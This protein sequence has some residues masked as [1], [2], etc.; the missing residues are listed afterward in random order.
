MCK[1]VGIDFGTTGCRMVYMKDLKPVIVKFDND[2]D[3]LSGSVLYNLKNDEFSFGEMEKCDKNIRVFDDLKK[4]IGQKEYVW[5]KHKKFFTQELCAIIFSRL[6]EYAQN[7]L[8][9]EVD[10]AVITIPSCFDTLQRQAVIQAAQIAGIEV[11][12]LICECTAEALVYTRICSLSQKILVVD[13]G[14]YYTSVSVIEV[15]DDFIQVIGCSGEDKLGGGEVDNIIADY[16]YSMLGIAREL[17]NDKNKALDKMILKKAAQ[18]KIQLISEESSTIIF[19]DV[20]ECFPDY[21]SS[22]CNVSITRSKV[23]VLSQQLL[24]RIQKLILEAVNASN[25]TFNE[26]DKLLLFG[27]TSRFDDVQNYMK[28][29][30]GLKPEKL[31]NMDL[32]A[33]CGAAIQAEKYND[34]Y[35]NIYTDPIIIDVSA[36]SISAEA[37]GGISTKIIER[38][39]VIPCSCKRVFTTAS[40]FQGGADLMLMQG[41]A[42]LAKDNKLIGSLELSGLRRNIAGH[43]KIEVTFNINADGILSVS[44]KNLSSGKKIK[45]VIT[46]KTDMTEAQIE[47]ASKRIMSINSKIKM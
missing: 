21:A 31:D 17:K 13:I 45:A 19:D 20:K 22:L 1:T 30:C 14:A 4:K 6:K 40:N 3:I 35:D 32:Y 36:V 42:L 18:A 23:F 29:F 25:L 34:V 9:E 37:K 26:I 16:I 8:G 5:A 24:A 7:Q 27:K 41:E 15:S 10:S 47:N 33:A 39:T 11:K 28:D 43:E 2:K 12:R 38:N 44:A 46:T